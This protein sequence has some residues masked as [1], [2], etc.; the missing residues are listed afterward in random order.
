MKRWLAPITVSVAAVLAA[1]ASPAV[2]APPAP[3]DGTI[4]WPC[5][6]FTNPVRL[7][8]TGRSKTIDLPGGRQILASP[9]LRVTVTAPNG[10]SASYLI[11]G[12]THVTY[13]PDAIHPTSLELASTGLNLLLIP[14]ANGHPAGLALTTGNV[15]YAIT[16]T[17]EELRPFS[18][19]GKVLDVC[20]ALG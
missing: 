18:G 1:S 12:A 15:N 8:V 17:G 9:N 6:N 14:A 16:P 3:A 13:L 7:D 19:S 11:T 20:L 5:P 4:Y 10:H 2:A